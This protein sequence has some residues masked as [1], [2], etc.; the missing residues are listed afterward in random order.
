MFILP[1]NISFVES[2]LC[3]LGSCDSWVIA[4]HPASPSVFVLQS[5][6]QRSSLTFVWRVSLETDKLFFAWL[7]SV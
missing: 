2:G 6:C 3:R 4:I 1:H 7:I 5:L